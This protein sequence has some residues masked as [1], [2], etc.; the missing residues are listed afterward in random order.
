MAKPI[1]FYT[2]DEILKRGIIKNECLE[3][4]LKPNKSGYG[5]ITH[6]GKKHTVSRLVATF[7]YGQPKENYF[8][9]HSCDNPICIN[10]KHLR[11]GTKQENNE[12]MMKRKRNKQPQAFNHFNSRFKPQDIIDIRLKYQ[13]GQTQTAIAREYQVAQV[14]IQKIVTY[15]RYTNLEKI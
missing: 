10:P 13:T 11:W 2:L 6:G 5:K 14:T 12:D 1:K 9:L 8:A 4:P 15:K 7:V 3:W